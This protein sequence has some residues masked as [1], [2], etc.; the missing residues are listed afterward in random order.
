MVCWAVEVSVGSGSQG[1][2]T[3]TTD[4]CWEVLKG[5]NCPRRSSQNASRGCLLRRMRLFTRTVPRAHG[6]QPCLWDSPL[7]PHPLHVVGVRSL[8][9]FRRT[10]PGAHI[11]YLA[12]L[13]PG[14][15]DS[16]LLEVTWLKML[17]SVKRIEGFSPA[18]GN[19]P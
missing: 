4:N 14:D 2:V 16:P 18:P 13:L 1:G 10:L 11:P 8:H 19:L 15:A 12:I 17:R 3:A 9:L 6:R 5:T 7:S